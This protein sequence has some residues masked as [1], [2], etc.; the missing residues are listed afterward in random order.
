M[1][2][3]RTLPPLLLMALLPSLLHAAGADSVVNTRH[4]LS[5]S[6]FS[7]QTPQGKQALKSTVET[8]VCIFCHTPHH[9]NQDPLLEVSPLWSRPAS[10]ATYEP[11]ESAQMTALASQ[12]PGQP[13]GA[14]RLCL[15]CHDGTIALGRLHGTGPDPVYQGVT[16]V[17]RTLPGINASITS[18]RN[19]YL[20]IDLKNDHPVSFPYD[21]NMRSKD[22]ELEDPGLLPAEVRL[23]KGTNFVQCTTCHDPH[24][25]PNPPAS[26][27]LVLP[28]DA[29]GTPLCLACHKKTGW[30]INI[31]AT[32][33]T[34]AGG[35]KNCHRPHGANTVNYPPLLARKYEY[36]TIQIYL[37][38]NLDLCLSC[39][40]PATLLD[41]L[42][43]ELTNF[44]P[45]FMH[46][47][48]QGIP[49]LACHPSHGVPDGGVHHRH[50]IDFSPLFVSNGV[51]HADNKTCDVSECHPSQMTY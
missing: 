48:S 18:D 44:P 34:K 16:Y 29:T 40:P 12:L 10:T 13:T 24:R 37:S 49:C 6:G 1:K 46:V 30:S 21:S 39:H 2:N 31:H 5:I 28:D 41:P 14:S 22:V 33:T 35:C 47:S 15:S 43:P 45:H 17:N 51:Y 3:F 27:F 32:G 23:E 42:H 36:G 9:A 4:N 38:E 20:G 50:L 26:K 25:D 8:R 19:S 11:Y 7:T